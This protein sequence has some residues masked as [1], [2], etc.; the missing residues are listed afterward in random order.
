ML[1]ISFN[2]LKRSIS[3]NHMLLSNSE[4]VW[5]DNSL[6]TLSQRKKKFVNRKEN[7]KKEAAKFV[8]AS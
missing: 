1:I 6:T 5:V 2:T 3:T 8:E 7:V 4:L